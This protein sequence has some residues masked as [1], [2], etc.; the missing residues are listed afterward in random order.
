MTQR[1]WNEVEQ[2]LKN[3]GINERALPTL[4]DAA[5]GY[6]I[7]RSHY[8]LS[9]EVSEQV[10][11]RDLKLLVDH[12]LLSA[13]GETRG[14]AYDGSPLLREIYGKIYEPRTEVNPFTQETLP[15]P[16]EGGPV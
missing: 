3:R 2:L 5:F 4:V 1:V 13:E 11:S 10:A 14:R 15:S 16:R 9:A 7:R 8:M 6:K 12:G